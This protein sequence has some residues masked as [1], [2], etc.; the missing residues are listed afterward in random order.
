[1]T[2]DTLWSA[3][4]SLG[5]TGHTVDV[6]TFAT[7][8]T[9]ASVGAGVMIEADPDASTLHDVPAART[10]SSATSRGDALI[11]RNISTNVSHHLAGVS[12]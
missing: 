2:S 9:S 7:T 3:V 5:Q 6:C 12:S 1:M 10:L 8:S 4:R 11:R